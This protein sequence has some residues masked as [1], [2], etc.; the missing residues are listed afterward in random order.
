MDREKQKIGRRKNTDRGGHGIERE[1]EG[2]VRMGMGVG[3]SSGKG[4][5]CLH[6]FT[7]SKQVCVH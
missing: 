4:G 6:R 2:R 7:Y 5:L 1:R 3:G